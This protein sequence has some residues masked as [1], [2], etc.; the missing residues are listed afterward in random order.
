M[1]P[2]KSLGIKFQNF[3]IAHEKAAVNNAIL[4]FPQGHPFLKFVLEEQ[5]SNFDPKIWGNLGPQRLTSCVTKYCNLTATPLEGGLCTPNDNNTGPDGG[6]S[7]LNRTAGYGV[8]YRAFHKFY[9]KD[10]VKF[11]EEATKDSFAVHY[12][13]YMRVASKKIVIEEQHPLYK[14]FKA[15]CPL[16]EKY[17]L[18]NLTGSPY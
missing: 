8:S 9:D 10:G 1:R 12:W 15:N 16:T 14:I 6:F 5:V 13:N 17:L 7:I 18:R 4:C 2:K 3:I 11:V